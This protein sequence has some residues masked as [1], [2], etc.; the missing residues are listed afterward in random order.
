MTRTLS[1]ANQALSNWTF[2]QFAH[3]TER[4]DIAEVTAL[5]PAPTSIN[6]DATQMFT[7]HELENRIE[8][9]KSKGVGSL[10]LGVRACRHP[11]V[12]ALRTPYQTWGLAA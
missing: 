9:L 5:R 2:V 12:P 6:P 1:S 4:L 8:V 3:G 7:A 11:Q 10:G